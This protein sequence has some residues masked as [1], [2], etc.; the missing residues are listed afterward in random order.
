MELQFVIV[1]KRHDAP[2]GEISIFLGYDIAVRIEELNRHRKLDAIIRVVFVLRQLCNIEFSQ[3]RKRRQFDDAVAD[4]QM[5]RQS[6]VSKRL[7]YGF[8]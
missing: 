6:T 2:G 8:Q 3:L 4:F 5:K 1:A 7:T